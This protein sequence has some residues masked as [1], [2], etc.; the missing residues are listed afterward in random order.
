VSD[1]EIERLRQAAKPAFQGRDRIVLAVSGG[2]DSMTLLD[3]ASQL[4]E[5][6]RLT[7]ATLDHGTGSA[8]T[9]AADLVEAQV[10]TLGLECVRARAEEPLQT[11]AALRSLRWGFLR[12][13]ACA[14]DAVV[15]TGHTEDDQ[16]ETVLMRLMRDAGPR[17]L[18][19]LSAVSDTLRPLLGVRR[20]LVE[21]YARA[22]ELQW[23]ED[24]SNATATY[25]RNRI[26]RDLL[27]ALRAADPSVDA[28]LLAI[29]R[30]ATEWRRDVARL[31]DSLDGARVST[32]GRG[33]SVPRAAFASPVDDAARLI[34][35]ELAGRI[36]AVLDRRGIARLAQFTV[37]SRVGARVQLS[38]GWEV[39][40]SRHSFQLHRV[41]AKEATSE[42]VS[43]SDGMRFG[44]WTFRSDASA[45]LTSTRDSWS[46]WL[47]THAP[48]LVRRWQA[49]DAMV[50]RDGS[51]RKVKHL[52]SAAGVTGHE[53]AGW[54]VVLSENEIVWVPGVRRIDAMA[55]RS[56]RPGLAFVCEY[57]NR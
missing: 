47:P 15:C 41:A 31:C 36:G 4:V 49:G 28:R 7:V 33:V 25:H 43:L 21:A 51:R 44:G 20:R 42:A 26:R 48:L 46:S 30:S 23:I 3:V 52:L 8:A 5:R 1:R 35:P 37:N 39:V 32:D 57:D 11:E 14:R 38:G 2:V 27:P 34:W 6:A 17:G 13:V 22:R 53:R 19:G 50:G 56:G 55:A 16:I 9:A 12:A 40:R 18:A 54:P 24:P 10:A 29:A 45:P